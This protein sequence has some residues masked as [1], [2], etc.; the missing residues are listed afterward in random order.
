MFEMSNTSTYLIIFGIMCYV[1]FVTIQG[2]GNFKKTSGSSEAFFSADRGISPVVLVFSTAVSVFSGLTIYGFPSSTYRDGIGFFSGTGSFIATLLI[3]VIGYRLWILGKEYG[4]TTPADFL[5]ERYYSE[6][7]GLFVAVLLVTFIVPYIS[8][9][10]ITIGDGI[11]TTTNGMV[12]Y[13]AAVFVASLLIGSHVISGGMKSVAWMDTFHLVL[14]AGAVAAVLFALRQIHFP[15][16]GLTEAA[17]IVLDN[18]DTAAIMSHPGPRGVYTWKG[19]LNNAL[20]GA[21]ATVVWPHIFSR[22]YMAKSKDNFKVMAWCLPL[23]YT[24]VIGML[25]I[26]G[27][28][29][30]PAILGAGFENPDIIMPYLSTKYAPP[31]IAFIS[32]LALFAFAVS[33][34]ESLL[35]SASSMASKD[36]Y[37]HRKYEVKGMKVEDAKVVKISR[38]IVLVLMGAMMFIVLNKPA[39]IT[40]YAYKLSSPFFAMTLPA[41]LGGLFWRKGSKEGA[42]A[43]TVSGVVVVTLFTFFAKPP[44]GFSALLWGMFVNAVLYIAVSLVTKVP[45]E[46]SRKYIDRI[47]TIISSG[48]EIHDIVDSTVQKC[49]NA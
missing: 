13:V 25:M 11:T 20:T 44:L 30:A 38:I 2:F 34:S 19:T 23:V 7:Y 41:T 5:R 28:V 22:Q 43:G 36:L 35:L 42:I 40:D 18:P 21:I 16:G 8:L 24:V 17:K 29:L 33:T 10:V 15:N 31:I 9:Q 46:I 1:A 26:I 45:E 27:A 14:G 48:Q 6:G 39:A 3:V 47:N 49:K 37:V 12:P 4:F 32:L